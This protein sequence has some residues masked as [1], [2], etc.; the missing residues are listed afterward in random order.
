MK[1]LYYS[2]ALNATHGGSIQSIAFYE[3]LKKNPA[4]RE[5]LAYPPSDKSRHSHKK[6]K[7]DILR[8]KLRAIP[9]LQVLFFIRRNKMNMNGLVRMITDKRPDVVIIQTDSNILQIPRLRKMFPQMIIGTQVNASPFDEP[10]RNIAFPGSFRRRERTC[11]SSAHLNFFVSGFLRDRIMGNVMSEKR[12]MVV[13]NG[14][15]TDMFRQ[16][17]NRRELRRK[18]GL[19]EDAVILGYIGT[20]D[21]HKRLDLLLEAFGILSEKRSNLVLVIAGDGPAF[22]KLEQEAGSNRVVLTGW[23]DHQRICELVNCFDIGIHHFAGPYMSPLK[24]FEYMACGLP[25]IAPDIAAVREIFNDGLHALLVKPSSTA[26][27][28]KLTLLLDNPDFARSLA[29]A[30]QKL[31][32]ENYTWNDYTQRIVN[33]LVRIK[34]GIV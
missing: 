9:V 1:V 24:I 19:D 32:A 29:A 11:Y 10:F 30:G 22:D 2:T 20:I 4:V 13:H 5:C 18:F 31:I 23:V 16:L 34:A 7:G 12:D 27:V 28:E 8:R 26:I 25:V 15:D 14:T 21:F 6:A 3:S 17:P 33:E